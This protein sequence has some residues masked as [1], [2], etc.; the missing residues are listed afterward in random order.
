MQRVIV[1]YPR[2]SVSWTLKDGAVVESD[3]AR[4]YGP[5]EFVRE[6]LALGLKVRAPR[7]LPAGVDYGLA[8]TLLRRYDRQTLLDYAD[9]WWHA[10]AQ[11]YFTDPTVSPMRLFASRIPDIERGGV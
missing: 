5:R 9:K 4:E 10:F 8:V 6:F 7:R 11:P 1:D 2:F 3:E